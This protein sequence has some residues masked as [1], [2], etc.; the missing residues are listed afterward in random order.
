MG[1]MKMV[2][3]LGGM[4]VVVMGR[5]VVRMGGMVVVVKGRMLVQMGGQGREELLLMDR[6][7][8]RAGGEG[9]RNVSSAISSGECA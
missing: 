8:D 7:K 9:R 4:A 5:M 2:V 1:G 3:Q 6:L